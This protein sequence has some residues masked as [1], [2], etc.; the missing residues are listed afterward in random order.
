MQGTYRIYQNGKLVAESKNVITDDGARVIL[1]FMCGNRGAIAQT[2]AL[3][4]GST[5]A[6]AADKTLGFE[7]ASQDISFVSP[8]YTNENIVFKARFDAFTIG[9]INEIGLKSSGLYAGEYDSRGLLTFDSGSEEWSA[10]T[11][12]TGA[13]VGAQKLRL[14][15]AASATTTAENSEVFLDLSGYSNADNFKLLYH[16]G[17]ANTSN[18]KLRFFVDGSNYYTYTINTPTSGTKIA[19]FSKSGF[20]ATGSPDWSAITYAN[21]SVTATGGGSAQVD[22]DSLRIEDTD[23]YAEDNL[24]VSRTVLVSPL[25]LTGGVPTEIEYTLDITIS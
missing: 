15:P 25:A 7:W 16:V 1:D 12:T 19:T 23:T 4:A 20:V 13:L 2:L 21:V 11:P 18:V 22:F 10:G 24:L 9:T 14:S 5:A 8:D 3:G 17:N 6:T